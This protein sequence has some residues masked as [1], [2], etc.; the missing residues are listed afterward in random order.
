M[1]YRVCA[2]DVGYRNMAWC[3][4]TSNCWRGLRWQ[5]EDLWSR[6]KRVPNNEDMVKITL[7]WCLKHKDDLDMCDVIVLERQMRAPF[8]IMNA[9][10]T[11]LYYEKVQVVHPQT[12]GA[13]FNLPRTRVQKK[14][15]GI[16]VVKKNGLTFGVERNDKY[17]DLADA[18]LMMVWGL[19]ANKALNKDEIV[20]F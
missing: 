12:V 10:I 19:V 14:A 2:I 1:S 13:F 11:T 8:I 3:I 5:K 4:G 15:A 20:L 16:M 9:V 6:H 7:G 17:D 18:W